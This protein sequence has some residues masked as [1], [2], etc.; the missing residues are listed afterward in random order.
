[1]P[2]VLV[3]PIEMTQKRGRYEQILVEAGFEVV[4]RPAEL[5]LHDPDTLI[6]HLRG[7]DAIVAGLETFNR[8]VL[9]SCEL[10]AI[11]R[12]GVGY[13][14]VDVPVATELGVAVTITPGTNHVS[15]AEHTLAMI[16]GIMRGFPQRDQ[17]VRDGSW[18]RDY[19]PRLSG[20]TLGLVGLGRIGKAVVPRTG[21]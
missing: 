9:E 10:R 16:L 2:R 6:R 11:A 4:N 21:A 13:D 20:K 8:H 5:S 12:Y 17:G 15:V 14:A 3:S 7:V 19:L 18:R 1:M